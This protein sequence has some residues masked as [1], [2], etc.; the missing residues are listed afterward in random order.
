MSD[1]KNF[2]TKRISI[3]FGVR[4]FN[5]IITNSPNNFL[6]AFENKKWNKKCMTLKKINK[7]NISKI[8]FYIL[9]MMMNTLCIPNFI[10]IEHSEVSYFLIS[11]NI[12]IF[13][14]WKKRAPTSLKNRSISLDQVVR[15]KNFWH[16]EIQ[17]KIWCTEH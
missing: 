5:Y 17:L 3:K 13:K 7:I 4:I 15:L 9:F 6:F 8:P 10:K 11:R 2:Y 16:H 14:I 12:V 1:P